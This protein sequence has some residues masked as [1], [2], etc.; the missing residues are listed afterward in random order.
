MVEL[1]SE[2]PHWVSQSQFSCTAALTDVC[3]LAIVR[4]L[5]SSS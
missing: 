1:R 2:L 4:M 5:P 3:A